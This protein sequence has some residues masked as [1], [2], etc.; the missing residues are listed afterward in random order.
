[1]ITKIQDFAYK[2]KPMAHQEKIFLETRDRPYYALFWEMGT[3]KTKVCIDTAAYLFLKG[4]IDGVL[5]ISDKGA[6]RNWVD[7]EVPIHMP[8][9]VPYRQAVWQATCGKKAQAKFNQLLV[10]HDNMLDILVMNVEAFAGDKAQ[11]FANAFLENHY[12]LLIIDESDS[13]KTPTAKRTQAIIELKARADYRRILTGTPIANSPLDIFSQ[14]EFLNRGL[15]GDSFVAFRAEYA[16]LL[17]IDAGRGKK[18]YKIVSYKNI[19]K[20]KELI[21]PWSSRLLKTECLDLPEKL[22]TVHYVEHTPEQ[23]KMYKEL[24]E[25]ALTEYAGGLLTAT[26]AMTALM[27]LHQ[28]NCGH[29]KIDGIDDEDGVTVDIPSNRLSALH[30]L[31]SKVEGK[32]I[33]WANFRRD[34]ELIGKMLTKE[35]GAESFVTYYGATHQDQ[36][37]LNVERFRNDPKCRFFVSNAATGGRSLTL[38][39]SDYAVYYSYSWRLALRLQSEDRNHRKGQTRPC[40]YVDLCIPNTVD[41]K[42]RRALQAKKELASSVLDNFS[43]LVADDDDVV[44]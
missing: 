19:E 13:I 32:V 7:P 21:K 28:I 10:P 5:I 34:F 6:Y 1:M 23:A 30:E 38:I 14:A 11:D 43:M 40:T 39:E 20:L 26:S 36:R 27:K 17:L 2:T 22:Y 4:E 8:D 9:N 35:F 24:K 15:L 12:T 29:V 31:L 42:I 25:M 18:Y 16:N 44:T 37:P 3:G 33:I 41:V